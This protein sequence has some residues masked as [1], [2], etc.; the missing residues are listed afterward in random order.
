[1]DFD[2]LEDAPLG[3]RNDLEDTLEEPGE[4]MDMEVMRNL[5]ETRLWGTE[6]N[7]QTCMNLFST[8]LSM[9]GKRPADDLSYY[10]RQMEQLAVS[11]SNVLNLNCSH[12][13]D[14]APTRA[15]YYQLIQIPQEII[16]ILDHV[17]NMAYT[18]VTGQEVG[19]HSHIS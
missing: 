13:L 11:G 5:P 16:P 12:L 8:F 3:A 9:F 4:D 7:A 10:E 17:A 2:D 19:S 1:M 14:F 15:F 18:R 6:I